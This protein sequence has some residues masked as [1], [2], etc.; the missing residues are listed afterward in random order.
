[1]NRVIVLHVFF[2]DEEIQLDN[3]YIYIYVESPLDCCSMVSY[4]DPW[5]ASAYFSLWGTEKAGPLLQSVG[6]PKRLEKMKNPPWNGK[7]GVSR[8]F[9]VAWA[10][11]ALCLVFLGGHMSNP[12]S[13]VLLGLQSW[14]QNAT[15]VHQGELTQLFDSSAVSW[16]IL[17]YRY[18]VNF[19]PV[20]ANY[21]R[22]NEAPRGFFVM[23][24]W[25]HE[26]WKNHQ[27]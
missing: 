19:L 18:R 26:T 22:F 11:L 10:F 15:S 16:L 4:I 12:G 20:P 21:L 3:E 5:D 7:P 13:R 23:A 9:L 27:C 2:L 1:M 25:I 6:H 8:A 14:W 17:R 24:E